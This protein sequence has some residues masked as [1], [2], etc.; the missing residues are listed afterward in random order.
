VE[1]LAGITPAVSATGNVNLG[2]GRGH[3]R[4]PVL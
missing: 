2:D 1:R 4:K 3:I